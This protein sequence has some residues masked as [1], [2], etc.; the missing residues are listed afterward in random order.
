[1]QWDSPR[2]Y[3]DWD[4][5][6]SAKANAVADARLGEGNE[7]VILPGIDATTIRFWRPQT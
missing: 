5:S 4:G 2:A 7:L 6:E 3:S 1:M